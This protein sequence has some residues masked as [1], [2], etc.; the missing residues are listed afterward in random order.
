MH[1]HLRLVV[2]LLALCLAA[3]GPSGEAPL[4]EALGGEGDAPH[5]QRRSEIVGG[6]VDYGSP[7]VVALTRRFEHNGGWYYQSYCSG[8]LIAPQTVLTAAHCIQNWGASSRY[9]TF[10]THSMTPEHAVHVA[11]Q[12]RFPGYDNQNLTGDIAVIKL[13]QP[14]THLSPAVINTQALDASWEGKPIRHSGFGVTQ[15]DTNTSGLKREATYNI[16]QITQTMIESGGNGIQ[17]C[18]GDSGGPGFIVDPETGEEILAGVVSFGDENCA[19]FGVDTNVAYYAGWLHTTMAG[20]EAPSCAQDGRCAQGCATP[21][22]DCVCVEDGVC[23]ADCPDLAKDPDCPVDCAQNGV[24]SQDAC[25]RPDPDCVEVGY[26]CLSEAV[27]K[28]RLCMT[29]GQ[30]SFSYCTITCA[31]DGD[32]GSSAMGCTGG[33]CQYLQ[34]PVRNFGEPCDDFS[35]CV[36]GAVCTGEAA[37]KTFCALACGDNG[38]C[39]GANHQCVSGFDGD[40]YCVGDGAPVGNFP[41]PVE[42][43]PLSVDRGPPTPKPEPRGGCSA[44]G[45]GNAWLF[46]LGVFALVFARRTRAPGGVK[47]AVVAV[48]VSALLG[49]GTGTEEAAPSGADGFAAAQAGIVGG[50]VNNGDPEVFMLRMF[51]SN[52]SVSGCTATLIA[53]RTLLTA[54]HC[55]DP[56]IGNSGSVSI[57]ATNVTYANSAPQN[58]YIPV[59]E[60]RMHPGWDANG[61]SLEHD[62][63]V[64]LLQFAPVGITPKEWNTQSLFGFSGKPV[65]AVGYGITSRQQEGSSG[66]KRQVNLNVS[67][68]SSTHFFIGDQ[69]GKGICSGDSGGPTFHTFGDGREKVIGVHSFDANGVCTYGG[70]IRVDAYTSFINQWLQEKEAPTCAADSKCKQGCAPVDVDCY[71]VQN[72]VCDPACPDP[73]QDP[74]CPVDCGFNGVCSIEACPKKDPDCIDDGLACQSPMVCEGRLCTTDPQRSG[75]YCSRPCASNTDC[76]GGMACYDGLCKKSQLPEADIG[77][78]CTPGGTFCLWETKCTGPANGGATTCRVTCSSN[79]ECGGKATCEYGQGWVRY[80]QEQWEPPARAPAVKG[81]YKAAEQ[82]LLAGCSAAPGGSPVWLLALGLGLLPLRRRAGAR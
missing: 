15:P 70:D 44:S 32:C 27:C 75:T 64:A 71:C 28:Q 57:Y 23:S 8:T 60:Y 74:D 20:W 81:N 68:L 63:A 43:G 41:A 1:R 59:V 79:A 38:S 18:S 26:E 42:N 72:D 35:L 56:A 77:E 6:T 31:V 3:C 11:E 54:A 34:K 25:P 12:F 14:V 67:N 29:D 47:T 52:G 9:V 48:G 37:G 50:S 2:P 5:A 22:L 58:A 65:R 21:D 55:V 19:H 46:G 76:Q 39:P 13:A 51:Y 7:A 24:C 10:G 61:Q 69:S 36:E 53:E 30:T 45:S 49:C 66:T 82:G 17:T 73:A 78:P 40:V 33:V 16:R 4:G 62:I 80:C